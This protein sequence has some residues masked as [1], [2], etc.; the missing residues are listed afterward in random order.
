MKRHGCHYAIYILSGCLWILPAFS[1]SEKNAKQRLFEKVFGNAVLLNPEIHNQV[2]QLE[3]GKRLYV[4]GNQDGRPDEVWFID[5]DS[6]HPEKYRPLLVRVIDEDGDLREGNE[7][8]LDS[9]LYIADWQ[10]DGAVDAVLD[11]T[12]VDGDDDVDEMGIFFHDGP[13]AFWKQ[14]T[15][16]IWWGRDTGDDNLLWFDV[17]YTYDQTLCQYRTH[18]GG[19][20]EFVAFAITEDAT[21]WTPF[22]ENPFL[23]YDHDHDGV[24]EE[25]LRF[26]GIGTAVENI[27]HSFDADNDATPDQP[28]DFDVSLT[29]WAPGASAMVKNRPRG[30]SDLHFDET[31]AERTVIRGL[32]TGPFLRWDI[33]PRFALPVRWERMML[34]WDEIDSNIDGQ[35]RAD[36]NERWEGVIA[37]GNPDFP[38]VGGPSCGPFNKRYELAMQPQSGVEI[39][40]HPTDQRIH[41]K[42]AARAWMDVD[43][44][45]DNQRD[46]R[47]ELRDANG[48]GVIDTWDF[49]LDADGQMD[50]TWTSENTAIQKIGWNWPEINSILA[51]ARK[52]LPG[53]LYR[54]NQ[55]LA[56]SLEKLSPQSQV[57]QL[58]Q[59]WD[60]L[61]TGMDS[62]LKQKLLQSDETVCFYLNLLQDRLLARFHQ[63]SG[64]ASPIQQSLHQ[65]RAR[66]DW[67]GISSLLGKEF[68]INNTSPAYEDW[69]TSLRRDP[70]ESKTAWAQ[71]WVPPNIGW[72]SEKIAYRAYWG[73]FDFFG[74]KQDCLIYPAIG[75]Q[76]YHDET[77]WGIDALLVGDSPGS[78]G[79]TL[80]VN[81]EAYPV[82]CAEGKCDI[83]FSKRMIESSPN[84]TLIEMQASGVGPKDNPYTVRFQCAA[85]AGRADTPIH[86]DI[87]GGKA[88]DHLA[89]GIGLTK[90]PEETLQLDTNAGV[91]G[92]WGSQTPVIGTIGMGIVFPAERFIQLRNWPHENQV[93]LKAEHNQPI[94]Y[95][96]QCDWLRGRRFNR[97]PGLAEWVEELR[98]L[99]ARVKVQSTEP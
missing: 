99:A 10:A 41:L 90:L 39:Y 25:V 13:S 68:G 16:R 62:T 28:R 8:D 59:E 49:D 37:P 74:K 75:A 17:G 54:L 3:A 42:G 89:L 85:L 1:Q 44:N 20:E 50:D 78:G 22:F 38:Q 27:R 26:S 29:A 81:G 56:L 98:K 80:Y 71:D 57:G 94:T 33:A 47:Y 91:L 95:Y 30:H 15:L 96:I 18:F 11:Y 66:G 70:Q 92:V 51:S 67:D 63:L 9:D 52:D 40:Y 82:W 86:I 77:E 58:G 14:D 12:D 60:S 4:D 55:M 7:P 5:T 21:E 32:P 83:I 88:G 43:S 93:V 53:R 36:T 61:F 72:E 6:R 24:T 84:R 65:A 46:S 79:I 76:S 35:G 64:I 45:L 2:L 19:D 34:T 87:S 69:I 48:D 23:F 73:Q 31:V 97:C